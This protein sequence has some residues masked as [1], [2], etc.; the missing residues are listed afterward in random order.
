[1]PE[2]EKDISI[3]V[4]SVFQKRL[5][6]LVWENCPE[7][8]RQTAAGQLALSLDFKSA[9][10]AKKVADDLVGDIT[11]ALMSEALE[12]ARAEF[13]DDSFIKELAQRVKEALESKFSK[14]LGARLDK[15]IDKAINENL[16]SCIY[17]RVIAAANSYFEGS[18]FATVIQRRVD[19][20]VEEHLENRLSTNNRAIAAIRNG[21]NKIA[22]AE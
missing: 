18:S 2:F 1:M 3:P 15:A 21:A 22:Q 10:I 11:S 16:Q 8:A 17:D 19:A 5:A 7:L 14:E 12:K 9:N 4:G 13:A 6:E 20:L